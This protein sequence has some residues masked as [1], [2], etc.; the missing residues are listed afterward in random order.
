MDIYDVEQQIM[1]SWTI[2]DDITMLCEKNAPIEAFQNLA[3]VYNYQFSKLF[4]TYEEFLKQKI[5]E[6]D[7]Q[8]TEN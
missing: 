6:E 5:K 3:C 7:G 8:A 4:D 1:R 2:V